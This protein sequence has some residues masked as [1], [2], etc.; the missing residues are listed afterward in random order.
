MWWYCT[1]MHCILT[2]PDTDFI[3][4]IISSVVQNSYWWTNALPSVRCNAALLT[5]PLSSYSSELQCSAAMTPSPCWL[6]W[7]PSCRYPSKP[8]QMWSFSWIGWSSV[9]PSWLGWTYSSTGNSLEN[10]EWAR[11]AALPRKEGIGQWVGGAVHWEY[12]CVLD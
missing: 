9:S 2:N 3:P 1:S 5:L 12:T 11:G 4:T 6:R 7:P 8:N 10:L